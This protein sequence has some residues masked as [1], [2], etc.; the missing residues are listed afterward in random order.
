M[1]S[2]DEKG[3]TPLHAAVWGREGGREGFKSSKNGRDS[4]E[5]AK[6]L[7]DH[8]VDMSLFD[9]RGTRAI[10]V[11]AVTNAVESLQLLL[12]RGDDFE[13]PNKNGWTPAHFSLRFGATDCFELLLR[14]G[15]F[16]RS[17]KNRR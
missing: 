12:D 3:R 14:Y 10:H 1:N 15:F 2:R 4:P 5:C 9:R 11:A 17:T 16:F 8:G 6:L 7:L 13:A